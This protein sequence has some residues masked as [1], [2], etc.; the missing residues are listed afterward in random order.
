MPQRFAAFYRVSGYN[1]HSR[2]VIGRSQGR[3]LDLLLTV[4]LTVDLLVMLPAGSKFCPEDGGRICLQ[5]VDSNSVAHVRTTQRQYECNSVIGVN[6]T[7]LDMCQIIQC[8][9][10]KFC[11]ADL[12]QR[13]SVV[14]GCC[15]LSVFCLLSVCFLLIV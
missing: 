3:I 7:S 8:V 1:H 15:L 5:N 11:V 10:V 2:F 4:S 13:L 12:H 6:V 9:S 14:F